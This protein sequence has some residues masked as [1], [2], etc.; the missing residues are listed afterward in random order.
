[1]AKTSP[2]FECTAC[3]ARHPKALGKCTA[4]GAWDTVQ[5]VRG[6]LKRD[7]Q[8]AGSAYAQSHYTG[9][10]ALPD[11]EITD[12]QRVPTGLRELDRVLGGGVVPG[13]VALL[14]GEPGIGKSTLL[15]QWAATTDGTVLYASGE[16]SER[17]IKLRAQRLGAENPGIHLLAETDVRRILE[18]AERMKPGL[19]LVDSIQTLFDPDFESS[20]GSVSQ[21]RGCAAML[22][23][24]AK[25]TGTPLVLVGHVTKDG[26]LAGPKVLE[27]LVDTVLAFE[28]D[29]HHHHRLLRALK[30]RFGAAFELGVFAMTEK[31]LVPAEGNPFF[32]DAEPRPGC[33]A[34]VV[35]SGTRPMVV[36]IQ[37]LVAAAGLG[38]PR[39]TA[40]GIDGQRLSMLCAV[41]ERRGGVQLHDRDVYVNVAGGLEIEDPAADLAVIA[42]LC[43][44]AGGRLLAEKC[45]FMGEVGL[46][47]EVRPV[48][49]LPLRLQEGARLGFAAA[50]VPRLGLEGKS[51]LDLFPETS[52]ERLRSKAWLKAV[53]EE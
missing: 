7:L 22:T 35:L 26:S 18:A 20:A 9:P 13:M 17:Q 3:G 10:V 27:H 47:G 34:T 21:V 33:A 28:G 53:V 19:L 44:S 12:T 6:S 23:R 24:W 43:S 11:V 49:Q 38:I 25:T 46:T 48:A 50:A 1:M 41:A 45:L 39:R 40:L 16:E 8:R 4:C 2:L 52:V 30:N 37:A 5:E 51:P 29:R 42:A 14:G 15:L 36:E 32:L 31:G